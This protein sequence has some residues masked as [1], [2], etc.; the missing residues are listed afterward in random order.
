MKQAFKVFYYRDKMKEKP[1][2]KAFTDL[3][4]FKPNPQITKK[5]VAG[6]IKAIETEAAKTVV[7]LE[8][9]AK[10]LAK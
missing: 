5:H 7:N 10:N 6:L 4:S 9:Y 8:E 3:V 1:T 2:V